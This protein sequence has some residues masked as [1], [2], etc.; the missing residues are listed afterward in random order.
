MLK[1]GDGP[2]KLIPLKHYS[3]PEE[4]VISDAGKELVHDHDAII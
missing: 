3:R 1:K 4:L 2:S